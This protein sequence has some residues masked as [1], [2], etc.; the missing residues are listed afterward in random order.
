VVVETEDQWDL[1]EAPQPVERLWVL[2]V[3]I[4]IM[5]PE[6]MET[7]ITGL[8]R[9]GEAHNI[10]L[11]SVWDLLRARRPGEYR[12]FVLGASLVIPI[13]KSLVSGARFL[14]KKTPERYM[15]FDFVI[16]MLGILESREYSV[17]LLGGKR[18]ILQRSEN[19]I[20][21]TF[22]K[23]RIVGRFIGRFPLKDE[24]T[25][26]EALRKASPSLLLVGKG[27]RGRE[28]WLARHNADLSQGLRLWCSDLF[29]VF[30]EKRRRPGTLTF[31]R[32]LEWVSFC[33]RNPLRFFRVFSFVRY[34]FLLL[35]Y[36]IFRKG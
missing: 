22:P 36:R 29:E 20:R 11:L 32:G 18:T 34:K 16:R 14:T 17:Y 9:S 7:T 12:N 19:N 1:D 33:F 26:L 2:R 30:A 4:D 21:R 25:I 6:T 24:K 15:P 31:K 13:S 3:P 8:V 23:L 10:V 5:S 27:V 28:K 35:F